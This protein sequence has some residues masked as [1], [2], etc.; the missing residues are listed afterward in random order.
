MKGGDNL[1]MDNHSKNVAK[2]ARMLA[3]AGGLHEDAALIEACAQL[4]DIGKMDVPPELLAKPGP[5]TPDE[6]RI[7]KQHA[8]LGAERIHR[9]AE[10]L[11]YACDTARLHHEHYDGLGGYE[12]LKGDEIPVYARIVGVADVLDAM[13]SQRPYK[14]AM[15]LENALQYMVSET[16]K[17]FDP[18]WIVALLRCEDKLKKTYETEEI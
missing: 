12:G 17:H 15:S 14:E 18:Q 2:I 9:M 3:E 7:V 6:F 11:M 16:G 4:H 5:L 1:N 8:R 10:F 13:V